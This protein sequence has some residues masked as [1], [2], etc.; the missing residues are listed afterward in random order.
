MSYTYERS[1]RR[2]ASNRGTFTY[3]IPL[4]FTVTVAT[5]G[6]AAWIWSERSDEDDRDPPPGDQV[7][8]DQGRNKDG[9]FRTGP[10]SYAG[11]LR[12]GEAGYGVTQARPEE[13][14]SY[15]AR[16]SGALRRT[17]SPQQFLD[18]ASRSV[19]AGVAAAGAAVGSALSS[20]REEDK[21]AYKDHKTWSEEAESR[22]SAAIPGGPIELRSASE[23]GVAA[24]QRVPISNEKRKAVAIV[25][26]ADTSLDLDQD[27]GA[28]HEHAVRQTGAFLK[29]P[30]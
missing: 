9:S 26:S 13:S 1:G 20:I 24:S 12:P 4:A 8:P 17:P 27:E 25:V 29:W 19:V 30:Y 15:M 10:P 5:F 7:R 21:N 11:D 16:M 22:P 6:I 18:G 28:F 3:W 23:P 14:Q 2:S